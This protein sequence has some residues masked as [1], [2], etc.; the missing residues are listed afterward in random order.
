MI[1]QSIVNLISSVEV[2]FGGKGGGTEHVS[3]VRSPWEWVGESVWWGLS[4]W[5]TPCA[6][7]W[8]KDF[9]VF[10]ACLHIHIQ[11]LHVA[12]KTMCRAQK[13]LYPGFSSKETIKSSH[14]FYVF[15][16]VGLK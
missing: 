14:W 15:V 10:P 12:M 16:K 4:R 3:V 13:R 1:E 7:H 8:M 6:W 5:G 11:Y 2:V 9:N